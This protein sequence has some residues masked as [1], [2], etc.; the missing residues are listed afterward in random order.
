[1]AHLTRD[2][3][4]HLRDA[5]RLS[6]VALREAGIQY[7]LCGGYA[8]FARGGPEPS[9]DVDFVIRAEDAD[10]AR[11]ALSKAGLELREPAEDWLFK[12]YH[13]EA[14]VDVI[15]VLGGEPVDERLLEAAETME[16]LAVRVPVLQAT[17]VVAS[18]VACL[19]EHDCDYSH[20]LPIVR[21]LREQ[22]NGRY[23][24]SCPASNTSS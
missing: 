10:T 15:Y 22:V 14:L 11:E 16:V 6:A 5:V 21:A 17:D 9:H 1:M 3:R 2:E 18:K 24:P 7:A 4:E 20:L 12:A 13:H 19:A 23:V 8:A